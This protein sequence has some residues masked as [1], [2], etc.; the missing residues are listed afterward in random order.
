M[1]SKRI[2]MLVVVTIVCCTIILAGKN[3]ARATRGQRRAQWE[4]SVYQ[5]R[6]QFA[7]RGVI[8]K[9]DE[10]DQFGQQGWEL[11]SVFES[12]GTWTYWFKR[13]K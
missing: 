9:I 12:E 11:V 2:V 4:Y 8:G 1:D 10:V 7:T 5:S 13:P 6:R 3:S